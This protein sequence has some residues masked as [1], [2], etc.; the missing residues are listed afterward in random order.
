[1]GL[2]YD[3]EGVS[4]LIVILMLLLFFTVGALFSY[5]YTMGFY[6]PS[7]F[8]L[9][10]KSVVTVESVD[11]YD[12]DTSFFNV[13]LLNPSYSPSSAD[14]TRI[15][16]RTPDDNRVHVI[17]ETAPALPYTLKRGE[18]K[19]FQ[20]R[21]NWANY[22]GIELP[23]TDEPVEIR[24]FVQDGRGGIIEVQR[25]L[26]MLIITDLVF[27]SSISVNHF[28]V[29]VQNLESSRIYVNISAIRVDADLV[30]QDM[31]TP[32]LPYALNLGDNPVKFQCYY[33]WTGVQGQNV[34]VRI[35]TLQGYIAERTQILP[36]PVTLDISQ[37]IFNAT[38]STNHFNITVF[39]AANSSTYVDMSKITVA[40][41]Q[42][43]PVDIAPW[44]AY[45]SPRL[46]KNASILIMCAWDWGSFQSQSSKAKVMVYTYQGFTIRE[47]TQIP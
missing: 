45:P 1:M 46:E 47:E 35:S 19:T 31:V 43:A 8:R 4:K 16:T 15:E 34:T 23:Y 36:R 21:W 11:F 7:E 42:G 14:I 44:T 2:T 26:T 33:N 24:V 38:V 10:S 22:T 20:A 41:D 25:P 9:P 12:Q 39:N 28:N 13:T 27:D 6:A 18:I 32:R 30:V 29:T 17:T 3:G 5:V 40:V 37:I